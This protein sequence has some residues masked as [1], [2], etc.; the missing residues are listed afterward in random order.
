MAYLKINNVDFSAYVNELNV[1]ESV[2][3]RAQTNAAGNTVVDNANAKR[4]IEVGIIPLDANI[5][6]SILSE[7]AKF[8]VDI[9]FMNPRTNSLESG[10]HCIIP[11]S[12]VEYYTIR[13]DR[14]SL[15]AFKLKFTEL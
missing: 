6:K 11:T 4:V 9:S 10:V 14:V 3:Y 7:V 2:T 1:V 15:K 12:N 13:A 8:E 5:V